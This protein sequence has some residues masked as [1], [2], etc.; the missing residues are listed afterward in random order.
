MLDDFDPKKKIDT[1]AKPRGVAALAIATLV[2]GGTAATLVSLS[3]MPSAPVE[4]PETE[5]TFEAPPPAPEVPEPE[6]P[7]PEVQQS[8][9]PRPAVIRE[10]MQAPTEIPEEQLEESE[11]PLVAAGDTGPIEGALGGTGRPGGIVRPGLGLAPQEEE[12]EEDEN[13]RVDVESIEDAIRPRQVSGC[14]APSFPN[15]AALVGQAVR[16][17]CIIGVDGSPRCTVL[18]GPEAVRAAALECAQGRTYEP[19]RYPSGTALEYPQPV[20]FIIGGS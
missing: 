20:T 1:A 13:D 6:A 16:L 4:E 8:F 11:A 19:A 5:V 14:R 10:A 15:D 17:R 12:D 3:R 7:E 18:S 2:L 9:D